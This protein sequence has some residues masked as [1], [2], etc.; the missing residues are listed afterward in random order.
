MSV[1]AVQAGHNI[2]NLADQG[3]FL[4]GEG[5]VYEDHHVD[6]KEFSNR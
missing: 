4:F 5:D 1:M 3:K 6:N 2:L